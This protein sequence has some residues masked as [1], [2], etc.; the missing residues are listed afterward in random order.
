MD[1]TSSLSTRGMTAN[2][3]T[4]A[5]PVLKLFKQAKKLIGGRCEAMGFPVL[6][7]AMRP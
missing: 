6:W 1:L 7:C 4:V 3:Q 5:R 2:E